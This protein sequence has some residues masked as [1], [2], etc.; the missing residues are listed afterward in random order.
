[1]QRRRRRVN[2]PELAAE[3]LAGAIREIADYSAEIGHSDLDRMLIGLERVKDQLGNM[4]GM[5]SEYMVAIHDAR[6]LG[7]PPE[8]DVMGEDEREQ[9]GASD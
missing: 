4:R 7:A 9:K 5:C 6:N 1:M 2:D 8:F 3:T